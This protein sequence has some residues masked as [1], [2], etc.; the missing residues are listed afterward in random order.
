[1][2]NAIKYGLALVVA[3]VLMTVIRAYAFAIYTV[4][5]TNLKPYATVNDRVMVNKLARGSINR[6]DLVVFRADSCYLGK[7]VSL[8]GDTITL[9]GSTYVLPAQCPC[10]ATGSGSCTCSNAGVYLLSLGSTMTVVSQ[11][12]IVGK[13]HRINLFR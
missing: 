10:N 13:A 2:R 11:R 12:Q 9:K 8:P 6:G 4:S 3:V 5:N 1:M 7:V